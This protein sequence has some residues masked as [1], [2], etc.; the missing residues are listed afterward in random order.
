MPAEGALAAMP[1]YPSPIP[2]EEHPTVPNAESSPLWSLSDHAS[3]RPELSP[4]AMAEPEAPPVE[5]INPIAASRPVP[6]SIENAPVAPPMDAISSSEPP[7]E[8]RKGWWQRRFK[9]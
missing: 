1:G 3:P 6:V 2:Q 4:E 7:R 8:A 9:G 5:A